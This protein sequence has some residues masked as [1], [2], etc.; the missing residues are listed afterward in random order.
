MKPSPLHKKAAVVT[1]AREALAAGTSLARVALDLRVH[2][3]T[4]A[5]W[6]A[7]ECLEPDYSRC[8]RPRKFVLSEVER[9]AL[10]ALALM[11]GSFAFAIER[12]VLDAECS[13]QTRE[14]IAAELDK[15]AQEQRRPRWPESLRREIMP[16]ADEEAL[17]RG[18]RT[19]ASTEHSPRK[20]MFW[21]DAE[22]HHIPIRSLDV[23]TMDDYSTN[24]PYI[25][26]TEEGPRL[27]RQVLAALDVYS[28]GWLSVEMIGR[29]RDAYRA[30][31]ILRFI[32]RTIDG[33]GTMPLALLLERGRWDSKAIHGIALDDLGPAFEGKTWGALDDLFHIEH[34][35]S[36]RHKAVIESSFNFLQT[37]LAHSGRDIGRFRGE[38]ESA[39]KSY[40]AVQQGRKDPRACDFIEQDAART[41]HW[42][43]MQIMNARSRERAAWEFEGRALVPNDLLTN[44][45]TPELRPLPDNKRW[46][47]L[48]EKRLGTVRSGFVECQV[49]NYGTLRFEVNGVSALH[50]TN[51]HRILVAFDPA[52][53][54]LGAYVANAE[55][56]CREGWKVGEHLITAHHAKDVPQFSL[57][58][59][60]GEPSSKAKANAAAR[61]SFV[62]IN[63]HKLGFTHTQVHTGTGNAQVART[64]KPMVS[65]VKAPVATGTARGVQ[66]AGFTG[67]AKP[68]RRAEAEVRTLHD[69]DLDIQALAASRRASLQALA[70]E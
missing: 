50:L 3:G 41:A 4:L 17:F 37:V 19:F 22:G 31:D 9:C 56:K 64:G 61:T 29:E 39:T 63:P 46:L 8:G 38:F 65:P 2:K 48:P 66:V 60:K 53:P 7:R 58:T 15:A 54:A 13:E 28:A 20:G 10:R 55:P 43:A 30:E 11:H 36:S 68:A 42:S 59:R 26:E 6:L 67:D 57:L 34:G 16:R 45:R 35:F 51:G 12:F 25:I 44:A 70:I 27:C 21:E 5:K 1:H 33:A 14:I 69:D 23:W 47:F 49:T 62:A 18:S 40:L 52:M 24:Q 32:E